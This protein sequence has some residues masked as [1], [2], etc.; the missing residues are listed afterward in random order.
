LERRQDAPV[1]TASPDE[2]P[3]KSVIWRV[4]LPAAIGAVAAGNW[5]PAQW[6]H[7]SR[8]GFVGEEI[9][10]AKSFSR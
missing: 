7:R 8:T 10:P 6:R 5:I 9:S 3:E 1:G 2:R 4:T